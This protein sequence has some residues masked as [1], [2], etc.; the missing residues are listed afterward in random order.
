MIAVDELP[1]LLVFAQSLAIGALIGLERE[2]HAGNRAGLRTFML[3]AMAGT[4]FAALGD[5]NDMPWLPVVAM[6]IA[7]AMM[8]AAYRR[9]I[10]A[11]ADSG[12]TSVIAALIT[13][14]LGMLLW[15]GHA[16]LAIAIAVVVMALLYFRAELHGAARQLTQRDYVSFLQFAVLAFVLL[17]ILP[18]RTY[19]PFDALNPYRIGWMVVLISGVSLA[20]YVALRIFGERR[21][22]AVAGLFGGLASTVATTLA[23][24]RRV[25][26]DGGEVALSACV[27][28]LAN[29][30]SYGRIGVVLAVIAPTLLLALAPALIGGLLTGG[31]Y[32]A[33]YTWRRRPLGSG[34]AVMAIG[35][36]VELRA[37]LGFALSLAIVLFAV[38][39]INR[40]AG[41][42]GVYLGAFLGGFTDLDAATLSMLRLAN[43]GRLLPAQASTAIT[44]AFIAN[45]CF[46]AGL[47]AFAGS[48]RLARPVVGGFIVMSLG[49]LGALG[50]VAL[51]APR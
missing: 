16:T 20:G 30:V 43:A 26:R 41:A 9:G 34:T 42:Y 46:K 27:I 28:L 31:I 23:F 10:D 50:L 45:F 35:N 47:A 3:I 18:D 4:L 14:G 1:I 32:T 5:L 44:I 11:D 51:G 39:W 37:A 19:D 25:R 15:Y 38:A 29:L 2:R 21:G 24:A 7:G 22:W 13:F 36:P 6:L 12:T 48:F 49:M 17:P 40:I 8:I 33:W